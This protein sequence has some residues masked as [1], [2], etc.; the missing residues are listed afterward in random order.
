MSRDCSVVCESR[1]PNSGLRKRGAADVLAALGPVEKPF[2][3]ELTKHPRDRRVGEAEET[4]RF[5]KCDPETRHLFELGANAV[6]RRVPEPV[7]HPVRAA[8][9][10]GAAQD[11]SH[12]FDAFP[13][14]RRSTTCVTPSI[15]RVTV[16]AR[17][18]EVLDGTVPCRSTTPFFAVTSIAAPF[19]CASDESCDFT[20]ALTAS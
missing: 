12:Y 19:T 7:G 1:T 3:R 5:R 15:P 17:C 14:L 9:V 16:S 11:G 13:T 20:R 4:P 10:P 6:E 8:L 2:S 18:R